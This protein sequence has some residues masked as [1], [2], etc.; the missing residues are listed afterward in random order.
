MVSRV[1]AL[2]LG[3]LL[4]MGAAQALEAPVPETAPAAALAWQPVAGAAGYRVRWTDQPTAT[5][6]RVVDVGNATQASFATLGIQAAGVYR[7]TTSSY[8]GADESP[9]SAPLTFVVAVVT[10][11]AGDGELAALRVLLQD[12]VAK[13]AEAAA[14]AHDAAQDADRWQRQLAEAQ[15]QLSFAQ[16]DAARFQRQLH[17]ARELAAAATAEADQARRQAASARAVTLAVQ[18]ELGRARADAA[19][20][21]QRAQAA[22]TALAK[23][24]KALGKAQQ[25]LAACLATPPPVCPVCPGLETPPE[26]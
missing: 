25:A 20:Y 22:E 24:N 21:Q 16:D 12:A 9:P 26:P 13:L 8:A 3:L 10:E 5:W 19:R 7:V 2:L 4:L 1:L 18:A 15:R 11:P 23:A 14:A 17:A 6:E